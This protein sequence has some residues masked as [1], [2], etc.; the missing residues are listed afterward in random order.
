MLTYKTLVDEAKQKV[1][2]FKTAYDKLVAED[3]LDETSGNHTVFSLAFT[4][5]L[6]NAIAQGDKETYGNMLAFL[7]EMA[8]SDDKAVVEVCDY[9]VLEEL[10]DEIDL[11]TIEGMLGAKTKEGAEAVKQYLQ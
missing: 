1:P 6:T 4:P 8:A 9:S 11:N 7:E 10:N 2:S 5:V 3:Y